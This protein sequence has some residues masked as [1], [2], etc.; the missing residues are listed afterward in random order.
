MCQADTVCQRYSQLLDSDVLQIAKYSKSGPIIKIT[1][2]SIEYIRNISWRSFSLTTT[3]FCSPFAAKATELYMYLP[4]M[5]I[6][7]QNLKLTGY[8]ISLSL[9]PSLFSSVEEWKCFGQTS[10]AP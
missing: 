5:V 2:A 10:G 9:T 1:A 3:L 6:K 7:K 4:L 8:F